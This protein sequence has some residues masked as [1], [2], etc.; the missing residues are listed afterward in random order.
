MLVQLSKLSTASIVVTCICHIC[1]MDL[2][3]LL[4]G[5]VNVFTWICQGCYKN[6]SK[7]FYVFLTICK[8]KPSSR[9]WSS[10]FGLK[11]SI[12][13]KDSMPWV[14]SCSLFLP[15]LD[16][17]LRKPTHSR[18]IQNFGDQI[19]CSGLKNEKWSH[20][21]NCVDRMIGLPASTWVE[22]GCRWTLLLIGGS[23]IANG[24]QSIEQLWFL[25]HW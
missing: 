19:S 25:S 16:T 5:F 2:S 20:L 23:P 6:L 15:N 12:K 24:D 3:K 9:F 11:H 22:L 18:Q 4:H 7:L 8:T 1:N 10:L 17:W 13:F 14:H 21:K